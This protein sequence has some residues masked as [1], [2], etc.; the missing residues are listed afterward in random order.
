[1]RN[2]PSPS[3]A[4]LLGLAASLASAQPPAQPAP[5]VLALVDRA[6]Q[7][8]LEA[9]ELRDS[10]PAAWRSAADTGLVDLLAPVAFGRSASVESLAAPRTLSA[11]V[12]D[13]QLTVRTALAS[14]EFARPPRALADLAACTIY[15][16]ATAGDGR[17][18]AFVVNDYCQIER[19][20]HGPFLDLFAGKVP[21]GPRD[22]A[23]TTDTA[24]PPGG[25]CTPGS[26][27]LRVARWLFAEVACGAD[28]PG[29]FVVDLGAGTTLVARRFLPEDAPIEPLG[30]TQYRAGKRDDLPL[31]LGGATG[32][33]GVL[34]QA[35]LP[36][37]RLG[38]ARLP[39]AAV[40]VIDALPALGGEPL[41][42]I[43]GLDLLQRAGRIVIDY[44]R[45]ELRLG[46]APLPAE[47]AARCLRLA[48]HLVVTATIGGTPWHLLV[49]T[50][51]PLTILDAPSLALSELQ[52]DE[53]ASAPTVSGLGEGAAKLTALAR[54]ALQLGPQHWQDTRLHAGR[55]PILASW[56][57]REQGCGLLGNDLL[58]TLGAVEFDV[59]RGLLRW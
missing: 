38:T 51:A 25:D 56:R 40:Q 3:A 10:E 14:G 57:Q 28:R 54:C 24:G 16:C 18:A 34:G 37:L 36:E 46:G 5:H 47:L 1:M 17:R 39:R 45:G 15:V 6:G 42:G 53:Q 7:L 35:E 33:S 21:L 11:T 30:M 59:Q 29:R 49:D 58:A 41:D 31:V 52:V 2:I 8:Q 13:G 26:C 32:S 50:G 43:L 12:K 44:G 48:S 20:E 55:L 27:P 19:L 23:V 22:Y 4:G 9:R